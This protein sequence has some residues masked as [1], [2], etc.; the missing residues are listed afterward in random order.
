MLGGRHTTAR[1]ARRHIV[2]A[3]AVVAGLAAIGAW[4]W[5]NDLR[6]GL[7]TPRPPGLEQPPMGSAIALPMGLAKLVRPG[8]AAL[9][10]FYN[11]ECP[12]SRFNVDAVRA[13]VREHHDAVDFVAIVQGADPETATEAFTDQGFAMPVVSDRDGA[14]AKRFGVYSTPQAVIL[15][16]SGCLYYRGNYNLARFCLDTETAFA[17]KALTA[18]RAGL[19]APTLPLAATT[20]YG[21]EVPVAPAPEGR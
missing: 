18:L 11:D 8:R 7:P 16:A 17:A 9:L 10:H 20:A 5:R 2:V 15:D 4:F 6:Y 19:P 1:T 3:A 12:C 21:C 14:I 13:L